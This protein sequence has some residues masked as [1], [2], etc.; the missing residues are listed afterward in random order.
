MNKATATERIH[1]GFF[2]NRNSGKSSLF[3]AV[4]GQDLAIVSDEL[5]TTTDPVQKAMEF[6]PLGPVLL[7][8]TAGLDDE[9]FLGNLRVEKSIQILD[10]TDFAIYVMDAK[11]SDD[12][13]TYQNMKKLFLKR[14]INHILVI[15]KIDLLDEKELKKL[16][17]KYKSAIFVSTKNF[18][19]VI[20]LKNSMIENMKEQEENPS[21]LKGV[22]KEGA[23]V[24]LVVP[25]DSEAPK[26]RIILP[27][28]Q[29]I[30]DCLDN[31]FKSIVVRDTELEETLKMLNR[32]DLIVTDSQ[33]FDKV[34]K[35]S[36][37]HDITSFSIV[38]ARQKGDLKTFVDGANS[39]ENLKENSKILICE[40]CTHNQSHEDIGRVKIP[41]LLQKRLNKK[42]DFDFK[43]GQDFPL[44]LEKYDLIIHCG[45]CMMNK[46]SMR[47]RIIKAKESSVKITNYGVILA[48][49]MGIL[50]KSIM[51]FEKGIK[52]EKDSSN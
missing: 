3:N 45:S 13:K 38:L 47:T 39:I 28:V 11:N 18:D 4:L 48:K 22:L 35:I 24:V 23:V 1:I 40:T 34:E 14:N 2:G 8:D 44:D 26:G 20:N 51:V 49:L 36:K 30:R 21:L 31:G 15:N 43:S 5:G 37:N 29:L 6:I 19:S 9:G 10:K 12:E 27:Q 25:I 42:F 7:M 41:T 16:K 33:A 17:E 50:D 46:K 52:D 32:V